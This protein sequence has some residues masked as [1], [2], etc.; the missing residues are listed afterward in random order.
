MATTTVE[1]LTEQITT[2]GKICDN[3]KETIHNKNIRI[4]QLE[5]EICKL[6]DMNDVLVYKT[7]PLLKRQGDGKKGGRVK[8]ARS[9]V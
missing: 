4:R 3:L 5:K 2:L 9:C 6:R 7:V 8:K 1:R